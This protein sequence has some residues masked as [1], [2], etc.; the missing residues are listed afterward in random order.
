MLFSI[1]YR[2]SLKQE[3][4]EIR[5]PYNQLGL[6]FKFMQEHPEKRYIVLVHE[7]LTDER[8]EKAVE[9]VE[10]VKEVTANYS[11]ECDNLTIF[12]KFKDLGYN[13]YLSF[14]VADWETFQELK[15]LGVTDIYIDGSLGFQVDRL[16]KAKDNI[17]LRTAPHISPN[18]LDEA[19]AANFFFIRPENLELYEGVFDITFFIGELPREEA[20]FN[21]YKRGSFSY[22]LERV[23]P[24]LNQE[25][26]NPFL[27]PEFGEHRLNCGQKCKIPGYVCH[28]CNTEVH[29]TSTV[30]NYFND[31][32]IFDNN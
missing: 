15:T 27:R 26:P 29:L 3:A 22:G 12:K 18:H 19:P 1:D 14:P 7:E 31:K 9:Q 11:I 25:V 5:C 21:I 2:S 10:C 20:L 17:C 23:I 28:L 24:Q 32:K 4:D 30:V 6:E 13:C 16:K 8:F